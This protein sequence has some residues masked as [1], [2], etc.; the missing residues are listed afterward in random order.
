MVF[1]KGVGLNFYRRVRPRLR[2]PDVK[3][4]PNSPTNLYYASP[5]KNAKIDLSTEKPIFS[6]LSKKTPFLTKTYFSE[7][8]LLKTQKMLR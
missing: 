6:S 2:R 1:V 3:N 8:G 5:L 4:Q 7:A